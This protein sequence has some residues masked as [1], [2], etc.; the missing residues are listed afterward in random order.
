[1]ITQM[2]VD[3]GKSRKLMGSILPTGGRGEATS[4]TRLFPTSKRSSGQPQEFNK[5][6]ILKIF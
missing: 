4:R 5:R 3:D 1:M 6:K 2:V